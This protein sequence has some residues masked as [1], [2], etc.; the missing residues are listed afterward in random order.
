MVQPPSTP[1]GPRDTPY[2]HVKRLFQCLYLTGA[3]RRRT[4]NVKNRCYKAVKQNYLPSPAHKFPPETSFRTTEPRRQYTQIRNF[5]ISVY[6]IGIKTR[7]MPVKSHVL[8][9]F[10]RLG[11]V[12]RI[13]KIN[14]TQQ[15]K[16]IR[17]PIFIVSPFRTAPTRVRVLKFAGQSDSKNANAQTTRSTPKTV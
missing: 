16:K 4:K 17:V 2:Y 9:K 13:Q 15:I 10:H 6:H 3:Q 14:Q 7:F 12:K 11:K 8:D 1:H 5:Y